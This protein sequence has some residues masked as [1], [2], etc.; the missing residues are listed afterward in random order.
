MKRAAIVPLAAAFYGALALGSMLW[1]WIAGRESVFWIGAP[2]TFTSVLQWS[3]VGLVFALIVILASDLAAER[4]ERIKEMGDAFADVLGEITW[5]KS[6]ALGLLSAFGEE[7][8]FRGALLP[9]F[10]L[11]GSSLIFA[12]VHWPMDRRMIAWP[13]FAGAVGL[14]F[15]WAF[16]T[17]GHIAGPIVAHF[18]INFVNLR[19]VGRED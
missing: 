18:F 15:G 6:L 12:L 1:C 11:F 16:Q 3:G 8:F 9:T 2:P 10:G 19:M 17:S 13:F 5:S 4:F 14:A 7:M